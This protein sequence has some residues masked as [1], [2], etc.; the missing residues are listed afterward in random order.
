M[1]NKNTYALNDHELENISAGNPVVIAVGASL[2]ACAIWE[3]S[4][5]GF[6]AIW[7]AIGRKRAKAAALTPYYGAIPGF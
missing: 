1:E 5:K 7:R 6:W 4:K 2:A 3:G